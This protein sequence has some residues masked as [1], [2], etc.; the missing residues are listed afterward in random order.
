MKQHHSTLA[1]MILLTGTLL[2]GW[3]TVCQA[4][5]LFQ[6]VDRK[7]VACLHA[8]QLDRQWEHMKT[9]E[10]SRRLQQTSFFQQ[11]IE[12]PD[13][14]EPGLIKAAIEAASGKPLAQ[15]RRELLGADVV[16]AWYHVP[17]SKPDFAAN[18]SIL[19]EVKD[20]DA[21][22][23]ALATLNILERQRTESHS[24]RDITYTH[25]MKATADQKAD[26]FW[27]TILDNVLAVSARESHI[28]RVIDL[29][30]D[31]STGT[32]S[33]DSR[34]SSRTEHAECLAA[35][36]PFARAFARR[37]ATEIAAVYV[38]P[39]VLGSELGR[40][41]HDLSAFE[42]IFARCQW[43]TLNVTQDDAIEL[44]VVAD[45]DSQGTPA[46]WQQWLDAAGST[47]P[48]AGKFPDGAL[49]AMSGR[50]ASASI[51][52]MILKSLRSQR[53]L[54]RDLVKAQ[55]VMQG[56]LLGLDPVTDILPTLGPSWEFRI[57]PRD[58]EVS[59]SFPV[60]SLLVIEIN[61]EATEDDAD[62]RASVSTATALENSLHS[63][64]Q[65]L[66]AVHNVHA[67]GQKV[68]I[69]RRREFDGTP[70]QFADPVAFFRPAFTI[71]DSHVVLATSPELCAA[72]VK[73]AAV[74]AAVDDVDARSRDENSVSQTFTAE[75]HG[76]LQ[77]VMVNSV[78]A[79]QMLDRHRNW[80]IRQ[81]RRDGVPEA[82]AEQRLT[83]LNELLQLLDRAWLT[84]SLDES[85]IRI[86]AGIGAEASDSGSS[87]LPSRVER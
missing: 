39:R 17:G 30:V 26:G 5:D 84:A 35:H 31:A 56:L 23:S 62:D 46:A 18:C 58:P 13:L 20:R 4:R 28:Q 74:D 3:Q 78:A 63:G 65:I 67:T 45:Y 42:A 40:N 43:L 29:S 87:R 81:A 61:S 71:S 68:S 8:R 24:H 7:A 54:P 60:D 48:S 15:T 34:S 9:S 21:A 6:L 25:S 77:N 79:R 44:N 33:D 86:S 14:K 52:D 69:V 16:V 76:N 57:E 51:A 11:L 50:V 85:T 59:T 80:F 36:R 47:P 66:A 70:I 27:Y 55:R 83:Q 72:F 10:F 37:P 41:R 12:S 2:A 19:L 53:P 22:E 1:V 75:R 73:S 38:N 49:F 64:L 82:E 32:S